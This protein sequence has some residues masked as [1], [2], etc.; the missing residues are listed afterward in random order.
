[1]LS[2]QGYRTQGSMQKAEARTWD[3]AM[4]RKP[5]SEMENDWGDSAS[6]LEG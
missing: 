4:G 1:M 2:L 6:S 3:Q 5:R